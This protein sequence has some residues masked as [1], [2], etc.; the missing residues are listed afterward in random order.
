[1]VFAFLGLGVS[2]IPV[3]I[4]VALIIIIGYVSRAI[5]I[6]TRIPEALVLILIGILLVP[7]GHLLPLQYVLTLRSLA[8]PIGTIALIVIMYSGA[9]LINLKHNKSGVTRG[10][11]F[12][13]L[14]TLLPVFILSA[15]MYV[16]FGWPLIYG[17][18]L[19][20]VVGETAVAV[21]IPII[22]RV[23][24]PSSVYKMLVMET[25]M[26]SVAAILVFSILLNYTTGIPSTLSSAVI[27]IVS[28]LS[29]AIV[30]GLLVG[31]GWLFLQAR[32]KGAQEYLATIA[33]AILMYGIVSFFN[34]AAILSVLI[35]AIIVGNYR[36]ISNHL[37]I[38]I[39]V[40]AKESTDKK[41]IER[42]IEF[43]IRTF[44]FVFIG[45]I[46]YFNY[47]FLLFALIAI[48]VLMLI[49]VVQVKVLLRGLEY[50]PYQTFVFALMPRGTVVAVLAAIL[51]SI[52]GVYFTEIFYISF[53]IIIIT[54]I[55][56]G[57]L[58]ST[59]GV[60]TK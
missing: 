2:A 16:F 11:L 35:F 8:S 54:D 1:M 27:Y 42:D 56:A 30:V 45:I 9:T 7:I 53:M 40:T 12:G 6:R 38:N 5:F 58:V 41:A 29:I 49:R 43:L 25:T 19:G 13:L 39:D 50:K 34:G 47:T 52:G 23:S 37:K 28:Y 3:V 10:I 20:A 48:L 33:I 36:F 26:N 44:F 59:T 46:A 24:I 57:V 4:I 60:E 51:Y 22:K 15:I 55:L 14:D 17:A 18:I 21:I 32:L 31:I